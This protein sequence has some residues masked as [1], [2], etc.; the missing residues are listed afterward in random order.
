MSRAFGRGERVQWDVLS[1][2]ADY[3]GLWVALNAVRYDSGVPVEGE[4][5]DADED[6]AVLCT[7][8]Q[9]VEGAACAILFCD[10]K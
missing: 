9:S 10:A 2:H 7:R 3:Q 5:I 8:I 1:H 6:I 4:L